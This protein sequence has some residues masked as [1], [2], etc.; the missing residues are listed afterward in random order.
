MMSLPLEK[1]ALIW[2]N[3]SKPIDQGED[4]CMNHN[5]VRFQIPVNCAPHDLMDRE[6]APALEEIYDDDGVILFPDQYTPSGKPTRLV[7]SCHGAGGTVST[8]DSQIEKQAL[9]KYLLA[10]G[11]A[12]MDVNGLPKAFSEIN[13]I[14]IKNNIG[15]PIAVQSYLKAYRYCME[16]FNL[17]REVFVHGGSMGGIS[18]TNLVLSNGIPVIA[19]SGFCP[20]LD[21]YHQIFLKP[22]SNGAPKIALG[23]L[24]HLEKDENGELIYDEERIKG[25]N[26]MGRLLRIEDREYLNYPVPVKFWQ[27]E[28][29]RTVS[30]DSTKR[31]VRAIG[32]AGGNADLCTFPKGGHE[33]QLFGAFLEAP[34]GNTL[35]RGESIQI[36]P[37]VEQAFL[38]IRRFD[39][40][41][42]PSAP[43]S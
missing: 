14:D 9:T 15:S 21:T 30:I 35:F 27:C 18:S 43:L 11:Y 19:Q 16:R 1:Q 10:N 23:K 4:A 22:W 31:F 24:Y 26:P 20:V 39:E 12:V 13:G 7:I 37:A 33:P 17:M 36:T 41:S 3:V 25:Y 6:K 2:Y 32:N 38:W 8:D 29:D 5:T 34:S 28:D 42:S 40:T